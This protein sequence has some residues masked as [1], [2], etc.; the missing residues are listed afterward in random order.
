MALT[1]KVRL[2]VGIAGMVNA[3]V[4]LPGKTL[5][6]R[7]WRLRRLHVPHQHMEQLRRQLQVSLRHDGAGW[8]VAGRML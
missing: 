6:A 3:N 7:P 5:P 1:R 8:P 2:D 4:R